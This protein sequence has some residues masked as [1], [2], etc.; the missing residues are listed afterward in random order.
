MREIADF[1]AIYA[2][3]PLPTYSDLGIDKTLLHS[4]LYLC[5]IISITD[6]SVYKYFFMFLSCDCDNWCKISTKSNTST[7]RPLRKLDGDVDLQF[8]IL[9]ITL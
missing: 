2:S 8:L 1:P 3:R 6:I 7:Y 4:C 9:A 5:L